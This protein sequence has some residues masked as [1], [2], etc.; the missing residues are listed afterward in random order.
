MTICTFYLLT[1][2]LFTVSEYYNIHVEVI[3]CSR[4]K[5]IQTTNRYILQTKKQKHF[6]IWITQ[7]LTD[8]LLFYKYIYGY[9]CSVL[10][11]FNNLLFG[12]MKQQVNV[13][14]SDKAYLMQVWF[15]LAIYNVNILTIYSITSIQFDCW[16]VKL[17][18]Y[19]WR[20]YDTKY[21]IYFLL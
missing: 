19:F 4:S 18:F 16:F 17:Y 10:I 11:E 7:Q 2:C 8:T 14:Q 20:I 1:E 3:R 13:F 6:Q 5:T 9:L 15:I 12:A 21:I